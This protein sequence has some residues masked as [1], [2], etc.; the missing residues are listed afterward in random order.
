MEN[1]SPTVSKHQSF[2]VIEQ[3]FENAGLRYSFSEKY[4]NFV[5]ELEKGDSDRPLLLAIYN[6]PEI[7]EVECYCYMA[8]VERNWEI[9]KF[10]LNYLDAIREYVAHANLRL[11]RG[12]FRV[13][14]DDNYLWVVCVVGLDYE[15]ARIDRDVIGEMIECCVNQMFDHSPGIESVAIGS[16]MP[17]QA[18]D[19]ICGE[20]YSQTA[21]KDIRQ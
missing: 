11:A 3:A 4:N 6:Y 13:M 14:Y 12:F 17:D 19:A 5:S 8:S 10:Q 16:K 1:Q 2:R 15:N 21:L 9:K 7:S 20:I 18:L